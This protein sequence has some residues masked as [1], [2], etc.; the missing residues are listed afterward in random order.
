MFVMWLSFTFSIRFDRTNYKRYTFFQKS[1]KVEA[2]LKKRRDKDFLD[3]A[4]VVNPA[5]ILK[6]PS[7]LY[8]CYNR[9]YQWRRYGT[10][11]TKKRRKIIRQRRKCEK[12][13]SKN[14]L[15]VHHMQGLSSE[16]PEDL[17]V[18]CREHRFLE[19]VAL[20]T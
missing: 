12:C 16:N 6:L 11:W 20:H 19:F 7:P 5:N 1:A 15:E 13:G 9:Y 2:S 10:I 4:G 3:L 14:N 17:Q 8:E 18:L